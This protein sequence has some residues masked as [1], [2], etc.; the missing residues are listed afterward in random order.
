MPTPGLKEPGNDLG[1]IEIQK[2]GPRAESIYDSVL[3]MQR[4]E[5]LEHQ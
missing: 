2:L 3:C 1:P 5:K 4:Y